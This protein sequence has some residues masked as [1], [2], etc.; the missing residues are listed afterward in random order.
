VGTITL[1][2][3]HQHQWI[4]KPRKVGQAGRLLKSGG[5]GHGHQARSLPATFM[6][7]ESCGKV[8]SASL[9]FEVELAHQAPARKPIVPP[10]HINPIDTSND[11][12]VSS[13]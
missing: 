9:P 8:S 4:R 11:M 1:Y 13:T 6:L 12:L 10:S 7:P 2:R 5:S 3:T